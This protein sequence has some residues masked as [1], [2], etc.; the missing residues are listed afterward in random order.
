MTCRGMPHAAGLA[1]MAPPAG[2]WGPALNPYPTDSLPARRLAA[3]RMA[4]CP[5]GAA[6]LQTEP[7]IRRAAGNAPRAPPCAALWAPGIQVLYT[8]V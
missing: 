6:T 3:T 7:P 5:A 8:L 1:A 2:R 4:A